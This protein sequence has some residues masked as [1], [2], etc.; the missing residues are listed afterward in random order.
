MKTTS[1]VGAI[2]AG[3]FYAA[4]LC[5]AVSVPA[6]E[7]NP[8]SGVTSAEAPAARGATR[9][10]DDL[11]PLLASNI[12][13]HKLPAMVAAVVRGERIVAIGAAGGRQ[14]GKPER[15]T[16]AD[17]FHLGSCTKAM[18]AT[19]CAMLVEERKLSWTTTLAESFPELAETMRPEYRSITLE[20]LLTHRVG[21]PPNPTHDG[22]CEKLRLHGGPPRD[23]RRM[24]LEGV[25]VHPL[26]AEPGKEFIY[27]NTG[28]AIA[29]HMAETVTGRSWEDLMRERLFKPLGMSSAGF[30]GPGSI[31]S[32]GQPRGHTWNG[33][34]VGPGVDNPPAVGPA[35]TVHCSIGDWAKFAILHSEGGRGKPRPLKRDTFVKLHT[36]PADGL[37]RYAM[38]WAVVE[39]K[40]AAGPALMHDGSNTFWFATVWIAPE[41]E[42]AVLV[43]TNQGIIPGDEKAAEIASRACE[44]A[45]SLL[46]REYIGGEERR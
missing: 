4:L 3:S 8:D 45:A 9:D 39:R 11:G 1:R 14:I 19:L 40:W 38:G 32:L 30:G 17:K 29:G 33:K 25:V 43:A 7:P 15:V 6:G 26:D 2:A 20:Q 31:E 5:L 10:A 46:I 22:L 34:P 28:Y 44:E 21:L 18:T 23:A 27:S 37:R 24:L 16:V 13:K 36:P 42:A 41:R 35:G 12:E